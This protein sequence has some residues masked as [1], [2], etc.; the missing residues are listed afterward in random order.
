MGGGTSREF[1]KD[2]NVLI[3]SKHKFYDWDVMIWQFYK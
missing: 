3:S 2:V 1:A